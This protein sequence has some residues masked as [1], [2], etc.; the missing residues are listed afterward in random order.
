MANYIF[1]TIALVFLLLSSVA[2]FASTDTALPLPTFNAVSQ[3]TSTAANITAQDQNQPK[4]QGFWAN[5]DC[6]PPAEHP[7]YIGGILGYGNTNWQQMISQDGASSSSTPVS[8]GGSGVAEGLFFG[9]ELTSHFAVEANYMHFP[10]ADIQFSPGN[11][12]GISSM[13]SH[14]NE[15]TLMGKFMVPLGYSKLK[16]FSEVGPA[17]VQRSDVLADKGHVG[18]G[19]GVGLDYNITP[20]WMTELGFQYYTGFGTSE[21]EPVYDYIPFLYTVNLRLAYRFS[22][23]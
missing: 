8:G 4:K 20:R 3:N 7:F 10:T 12:Y 16:A 13:T 15:Y 19:F 17:Y 1:R 5:F 18:A 11:L 9:Y 14:T 21:L 6:I 2:G 22:L 23:F